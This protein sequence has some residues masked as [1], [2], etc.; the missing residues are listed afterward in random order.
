[1][2]G[3]YLRHLAAV[4]LLAAGGLAYEIALTRLLS[5]LL[6]SSWVAPVLAVALL[7]LGLGAGLAA[8]RLGWRSPATAQLAAG[9]AAV[10][11]A[12]SLPAWLWAA[13][14]AVPLLGLLLPLLT[15][16]A[17]G[18]AT[19]ALF[20]WWPQRA[21]RLLRTDY[22]A[23]A[24]AAIATPLALAYLGGLGGA[25]A[26]A[27]LLGAAALCL[28]PTGPASSS[29]LASAMLGVAVPAL[30]ALAVAVG[31]LG[32]D[33]ASHLRAKPI[34]AMLQ[35]GG[36]IEASR[37]DATARTDL[38][39]MPDGARYLFMDGGAGSLVPDLDPDRWWHDVGA[40]AFAMAPA[41]RAFLIGTG[42]GLDVAQARAHGVA[43]VTAAEV[44][45]ASIELVQGLGS[46]AGRVYEAPTEVVL[47][48]GRRALARAA[49]DFDLIA[50]ANVVTGAA[51]LRGAALTENLVY[52]VEAFEA[53]L[54]RLTPDGRLAL[55]LYDELTL[56]RA[57][58]TALE[59]LVRSGL[60]PDHA[61]ATR[62]LFA[63]LDTR[64]QPPIPLLAVRR[65]P[66]NLEE[67][68][69]AARVAEARGWGLLL[70]P[71]LLLPA[72]LQGLAD[73]SQTLAELIAAGGEVDLRPTFDD[74]PYFF[75]FEP[76]LPRDVRRA[77]WLAAG[78]LLALL[79]AA[80]WV[81]GWRGSGR[82]GP[83]AGGE[84]GRRGA[85]RRWLAAAALGAGFLLLEL[86]ALHIVQR[87]AGHPAWSLSLTLGAVLLG[88]AIGAY[89]ASRS[90]DRSVRRPALLAAGTLLAWGF[91]APALQGLLLPAAPQLAGLAQASLLLL[92]AVPMGMPFPRLLAAWGSSGGVAAAL[93]ASGVAAV[94]A[95]SGALYI[96]HAVGMP[97]VGIVAVS[98]YFLAAVLHPAEG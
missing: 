68:V 29:R 82:Q 98:A 64:A 25:V 81:G 1:M 65:S 44:N 73:G 69:A 48:D 56:T 49:G 5:A 94:A 66:L 30:A 3:P 57:L 71:E 97:W 41:Q 80:P 89:L 32:I 4:G 91:L 39:R 96:A 61:A 88:G 50:L 83:Q 52:T 13:A 77:G 6:V 23:A 31:A 36:V 14:A 55:K 7:G 11:A 75:A 46:A 8:L 58:T 86:H 27:L 54:G 22:A 74:Q 15:N 79:A 63:V 45:A 92:A 62:H 53:Y 19:A 40:F 47:G 10:L 43:E 76:G 21:A 67:A 78:T 26:A 38:L 18:L 95:G 60:A 85:A 24:M 93:A 17:L 20:S 87:A 9:T 16:M 2:P 28:L 51:E 35:R 12:L 72:T 42:G 59:A 37:W 70:V 34:A 33:P 84:G 90:A